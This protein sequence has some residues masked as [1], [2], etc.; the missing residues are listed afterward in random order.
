MWD[1][2]ETIQEEAKE[3][4]ILLWKVLQ[5]SVIHQAKRGETFHYYL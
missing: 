5:K 3:S 4:K 2:W 1:V